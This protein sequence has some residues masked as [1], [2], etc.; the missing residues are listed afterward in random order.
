MG[1]IQG[2]DPSPET[3]KDADSPFVYVVTLDTREAP[4][5]L[6]AAI[7][8]DQVS[9]ALVGPED[10]APDANGSAV[11][12]LLPPPSRMRTSS[13]CRARDPTRWCAC[14]CRSWTLF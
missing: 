1:T 12:R 3:L 11:R 10:E 4:D 14:P 2:T 13:S 5:S 9:V 7:C 8:F 6:P